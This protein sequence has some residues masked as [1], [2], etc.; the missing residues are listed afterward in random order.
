MGNML[1]SERHIDHVEF[2][3]RLTVAGRRGPF[4]F[5]LLPPDIRKGRHR[6]EGECLAP[7]K[8]RRGNEVIRQRVQCMP[9]F[10]Q[11]ADLQNSSRR[12]AA[13]FCRERFVEV[14][15]KRRARNLF[16]GWCC[17]DARSTELEDI[18]RSMGTLW[19]VAWV[20]SNYAR[21]A[22]QSNKAGLRIFIYCNAALD[23]CISWSL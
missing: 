20:R 12:V 19:L 21:D 9:P 7:M 1:F 14:P 6:I 8:K 5:P 13:G 10:P 3:N 22:A 17:Y 15:V 4:G 23:G 11:G 2:K 18:S 16:H